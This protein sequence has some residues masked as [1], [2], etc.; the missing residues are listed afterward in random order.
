MD[1][2]IKNQK[3][4]LKDSK[5]YNEKKLI[6]IDGL[7]KTGDIIYTEYITAI[8]E[9]NY[10]MTVDEACYYIGCSYTYFITKMIDKVYHIR[11]NTAARKL[12]YLYANIYN[13]LNEE[14][15][16]LV[17]KRILISRTDFFNYMRSN[18]VIEQQ[19]K[20]F[21]I[22]DFDQSII[23]E[24]QQNLDEYNLKVR[25]FTKRI[26]IAKSVVSL[27]NDVIS[28]LSYDYENSSVK[29]KL[30]KGYEMPEKFYSLKEIKFTDNFKYDIEVYRLLKSTGA[31]KYLLCD[32]DFVRYDLS[33]IKR[34]EDSLIVKMNYQKYLDLCKKY[35]N[36]SQKILTEALKAS[37]KLADVILE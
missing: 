30:P 34:N 22:D 24:I 9:N 5:K 36:I 13:E 25:E 11:I 18:I 19:Y 6:R 32:E 33:E 7:G 4:K 15:R 12:I 37:K 20:V 28:I 2:D 1:K 29:L 23:N 31:R 17:N 35:D 10:D 26:K 8:Q 14:L 21:D 16:K 27:F 3:E